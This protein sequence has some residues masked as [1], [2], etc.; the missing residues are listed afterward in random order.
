MDQLNLLLSCAWDGPG[1]GKVSSRTRCTDYASLKPGPPRQTDRQKDRH[2]LNVKLGKIRPEISAKGLQE[3]G[4]PD[5]VGI[6]AS[7]HLPMINK[8]NLK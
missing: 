7:V 6:Q 1:G 3:D 2:G 4:S 8:K 5:S